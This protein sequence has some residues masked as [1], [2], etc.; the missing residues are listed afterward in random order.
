MRAR[1]KASTPRSG[2]LKRY[3]R[4]GADVIFVEGPKT[5]EEA[6]EIARRIDTPM[7]YNITPTGSVAALDAKTLE[8]MGFRFLSFSVSVLLAAIPGMQAFL[9][10]VKEGDVTKAARHCASMQEYL[11]ILGYEAWRRY[12][13]VYAVP[14]E[15]KSA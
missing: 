12:E 7:V 11:D 15:P 6:E 3:A 5:R 2:A 4:M 1:W 9:R 10:Q 13:D 8:A 14:G